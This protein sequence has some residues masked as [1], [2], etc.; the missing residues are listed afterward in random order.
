MHCIDLNIFILKQFQ[1][2]LSHT[3][4]VNRNVFRKSF[5]GGP[6]DK[7]WDFQPNSLKIF[8]NVP[9]QRVTGPAGLPQYHTH[10]FRF[11]AWK[12]KKSWFQGILVRGRHNHMDFGN[13]EKREYLFNA[14]RVATSKSERYSV[15]FGRRLH[16]WN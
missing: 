5:E 9:F 3:N 7:K 12:A 2:K 16:C 8:K 4:S 13:L 1:G 15:I 11:N 6:T 10:T 14:L